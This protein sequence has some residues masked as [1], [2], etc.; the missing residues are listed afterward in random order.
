M[1][2]LDKVAYLYRD[3]TVQKAEKGCFKCCCWCCL[4]D[5]SGGWDGSEGWDGVALFD[6]DGGGGNDYDRHDIDDDNENDN[7]VDVPNNYL[8]LYILSGNSR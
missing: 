2:S 3:M 5:G 8:S 1:T 4:W 7:D 6:G